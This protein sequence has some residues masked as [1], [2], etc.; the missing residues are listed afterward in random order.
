MSLHRF[1]A[2]TTVITGLLLSV[3]AHSKLIEL[4]VLYDLKYAH[5]QTYN[6][7][8]YEGE[9]L[10]SFPWV[11]V[12]EFSLN[13]GDTVIAK[14]RWLPGQLIQM[15]GVPVH[16]DAFL[17]LD[18]K[19]TSDIYSANTSAELTFIN[20]VGD[21]LANPVTGSVGS[22]G[23]AISSGI[24]SNLT[25]GSFTFSGVDWQIDIWRLETISGSNIFNRIHFEFISKDI[26]VVTTRVPEPG[27]LP[28]LALG[29]WIAFH[30]RPQ[31]RQLYR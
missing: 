31:R 21:L 20:P 27:T 8:E 15:H 14:I 26:N 3:P 24:I 23:F 17:Y 2:I 16:E 11:P 6:N 4:D 7:L 5:V 30:F 9:R 10:Y 25:D 19:N 1:I 18:P 22:G 12:N 29:L 28:L 13:E